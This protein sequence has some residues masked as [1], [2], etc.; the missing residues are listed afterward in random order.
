MAAV[1]AAAPVRRPARRVGIAN[2]VLTAFAFLWVG[3]CV[4]A[5]FKFVAPAFCGC[6]QCAL[7]NR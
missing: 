5:V 7:P 6:N 3:V 4:V 2:V 1:T